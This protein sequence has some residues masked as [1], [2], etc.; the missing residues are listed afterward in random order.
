MRSPLPFAALL[1]IYL[2]IVLKVAP[3]FMRKRKPLNITRII[4]AYNIFQV[5]ACAYFVMKFHDLGFSFRNTWQCVNELLP[6]R[7]HETFD[8][9]WWFLMLRVFELIETVFFIL[10]KKQNQVSVLHVYHHVSTIILSWLLL[11]YDAGM[12]L[13]IEAKIARFSFILTFPGMMTL[14][15]ST[16]NSSVHIVMYIFYFCSSIQSLSKSVKAMKP[17]LTSIQMVQL[18]LILQHS[19][20]AVSPSCK[21]SNMHFV[22]IADMLILIFLFASFFRSSYIK[23][24]KSKSK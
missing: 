13:E 3:T 9:M 1:S 15:S 18:L 21:T 24:S 23:S 7:E 22:M 20:I 6:G 19:V 17:L 4:Q 5:I 2:W 11:K 14:F 10:R 12:D 8:R 16:I